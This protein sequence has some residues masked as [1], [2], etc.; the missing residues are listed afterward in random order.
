MAPNLTGAV[1]QAMLGLRADGHALIAGK[2]VVVWLR[3]A[4]QEVDLAAVLAVIHA[5]QIER[6]LDY[7]ATFTVDQDVAINVLYPRLAQYL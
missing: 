7:V 2:D 3:T 1:A 6:C 5:L 4:G